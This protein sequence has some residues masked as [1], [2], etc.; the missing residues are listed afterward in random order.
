MVVLRVREK[1]VGFGTVYVWDR[2]ETRTQTL[3]GECAS[4]LLPVYALSDDGRR[5]VVVCNTGLGHSF[6]VWD[7]GSGQVIPLANADFGLFRGD[8]IIRSEGVALAPDGRYL[9]VA[10]LE[11]TE[12]LLVLPLPA[13]LAISRSDL[14]LW[15]VD[16]GQEL[17]SVPIDDLVFSSDYFRGIDLAFSPDGEMLAVGGR[18]LRIYRLSDLAARPR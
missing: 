13:P 14:R 10:L 18:R 6:R 16:A 1:S 15:D 17:I 3:P 5:L 7:L 8:P 9:A 11:L 12:A 4:R 2:N